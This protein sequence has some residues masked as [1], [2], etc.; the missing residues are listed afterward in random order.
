MLIAVFG[1][2]FNP[3]H[4]AHYNLAKTV[5]NEL[6]PDKLIIMPVKVPPHKAAADLASDMDR[7]EM[8]RLC[9]S[10]ILNCEVSD[11]EISEKGKSFTVLTMRKLKKIY[12]EDCLWFVMGSDM[13]LSF[14][15]WYEWEEILSLCGLVCIS[16][17]DEDTKR[18]DEA[19]EDL[20]LCGGKCKIIKCEPTDMSSTQI[21]E[22]IKNGDFKDYDDFLNERVFQYINDK[23]LYI[24]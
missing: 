19:A 22:K 23:M 15:K 17:S 1:G 12:P 3:P 8:C 5:C 13:L 9:F 24:I 14:K 10:D 6:S 2:T 20:V 7:L 11:M 18:L 21:R 4:K 16:R